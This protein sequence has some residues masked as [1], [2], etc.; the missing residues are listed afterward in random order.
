MFL[1]VSSVR[2]RKNGSPRFGR[3]LS[4][5]FFF[6]YSGKLT[7]F[8]LSYLVNFI[9]KIRAW[10]MSVRSRRCN[11]FLISSI[12]IVCYRRTSRLGSRKTLRVEKVALLRTQQKTE[13]VDQWDV[14]SRRV[15]WSAKNVSV[16]LVV[17]LPEKQA[18]LRRTALGGDTIL[19]FLL[20]KR[21]TFGASPE[22]EL[23]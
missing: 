23:K 21:F 10:K 9:E 12:S 4:R 15:E 19:V 18:A 7:R 22:D 3:R 17:C 5:L 16:A 8:L 6:F 11:K 2:C 1:R 20:Q 13:A 14:T